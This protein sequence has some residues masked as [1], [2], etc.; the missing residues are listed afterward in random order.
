METRPLGEFIAIAPPSAA[1]PPVML[2]EKRLRVTVVV[3][4]AAMPAP[5]TRYPEGPES[6]APPPLPALP[7]PLPETTEVVISI[8]PAL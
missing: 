5:R 4:L 1:K 2:P 6:I 3:P 7:V 8:E